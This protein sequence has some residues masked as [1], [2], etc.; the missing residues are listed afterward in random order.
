MF[1]LP[2]MP[3]IAH[4]YDR[5]A[6]FQFPTSEMLARGELRSLWVGVLIAVPS[7]AGVALSVLGGNN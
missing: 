5:T 7:G 3:W 1:G 6:E 2:I 4:Y